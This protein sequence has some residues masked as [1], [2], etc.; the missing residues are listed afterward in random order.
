MNFVNAKIHL[1]KTYAVLGL[2]PLAMNLLYD[3]SLGETLGESIGK[4]NL[5]QE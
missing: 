4:M 1:I 3:N 5:V 2:V